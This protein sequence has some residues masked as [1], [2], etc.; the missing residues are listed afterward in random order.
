MTLQAR[1]IDFLDDGRFA[2][3]V[4]DDLQRMGAQVHATPGG[5]RPLQLPNS[6]GIAAASALGQLATNCASWE[7]I[8]GADVSQATAPTTVHTVNAALNLP[9][10]AILDEGD[11]GRVLNCMRPPGREGVGPGGYIEWCAVLSVDQFDEM[12]SNDR[13]DAEAGLTIPR[14]YVALANQT[15]SGA[16]RHGAPHWIA[17]IYEFK[18]SQSPA[19]AL[20]DCPS[21][22]TD[23]AAPSA[24]DPLLLPQ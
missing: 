21:S 8:L 23:G 2:A 24:A 18:E 20:V 4:I 19:R 17:V 7:S 22:S 11:V 10:E 3:A 5:D 6:C 14:R 9:P 12:L 13:R 16:P 1:V 15:S